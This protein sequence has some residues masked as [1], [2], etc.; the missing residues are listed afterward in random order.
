MESLNT[1]TL[2]G[3]HIQCKGLS[4]KKN[5]LGLRPEKILFLSF[6]THILHRWCIFTRVLL[7]RQVNHIGSNDYLRLFYRPVRA[8]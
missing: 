8:K 7:R 3:I 4:Y 1:Y 5:V 6:A 2:L